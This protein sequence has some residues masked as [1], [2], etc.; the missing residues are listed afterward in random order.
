[1]RSALAAVGVV[2]CLAAGCST[3]KMEKPLP[4]ESVPVDKELFEGTW[5]IDESAL[6]AHF[7]DDGTL[8]VAGINWKDGQFVL[9]QMRCYVTVVADQKYLSLG[10]KDDGEEKESF[11]FCRYRFSPEGHLILQLP[12]VDAVASAVEA[13]KLE[14][15]VKKE[16]HSTTVSLTSPPEAVLQYVKETPDVFVKDEKLTLKKLKKEE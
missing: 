7:A 12:D 8:H 9:N 14:G 16:Q 6:V 5:Q 15:T 3:V 4:H 13:G 2:V 10:Y 1:M 11:Q